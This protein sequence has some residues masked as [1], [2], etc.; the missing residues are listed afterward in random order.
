MLFQFTGSINNYVMRCVIVVLF[1]AKWKFSRPVFFNIFFEAEPLQQFHLFMQPH[2]YA[3]L[4]QSNS[5]R[6][7]TLTEK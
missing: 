4:P 5:A 3:T 2:L 6:D 7:P 1:V